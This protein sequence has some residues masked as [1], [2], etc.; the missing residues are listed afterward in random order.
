MLDTTT[1]LSALSPARFAA[2]LV[3]LLHRLRVLLEEIGTG[4]AQHR[5]RRHLQLEEVLP[6]APETGETGHP[7]LLGDSV[8]NWW[9]PVVPHKAVAEVS[10]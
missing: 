4:T 10:E 1:T 9:L 5:G 2:Q 8:T 3:G 6:G 7:R